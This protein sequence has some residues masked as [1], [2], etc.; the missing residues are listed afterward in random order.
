MQ[1]GKGIGSW[2]WSESFWTPVGYT[3]E[4]LTKEK[5]PGYPDHRDIITY[6]FLFTIIMLILKN[7]IVQPLIVSPL[8]HKLGIPNRKHRKP[9][10]NKLLEGL[11]HQY[12]VTL[13]K[14]VL[15]EVSRSLHWTSRKVER[16][17]RRK[18]AS[19]KQS[20]HEKFVDTAYTWGYKAGILFFGLTVLYDKPYAW[21]VDALWENFP[22]QA[23]DDGIWWLYM[24]GVSFCTAQ[25]VAIFNQPIKRESIIM[26]IH[27]SITVALM[28][29]S[30]VMNCV[31]SG[32]LILILHEV[33]DVILL[34]GKCFRY[35]N[36]ELATDICFTFFVISWM[37]TRLYL[38]PAYILKS[39]F[40]DLPPHMSQVP[41]LY[42]FEILLSCIFL[43]N[44][45]WAV[46]IA[47]MV[48]RKFVE[49]AVK[50]LRSSDEYD[51][52]E[53]TE[54]FSDCKLSSG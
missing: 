41:A 47:A 2:F 7:A 43:L 15:L 54:D 18:Q 31:R 6:P 51:T 10:K 3:W 49:G 1:W 25:T 40:Y 33:N 32:A 53:D 17:L 37:V 9:L 27:H 34:L 39:I 16:W 4:D 21:N 20:E 36:N 19:L 45:Y 29:F 35:L 26:I 13:P 5:I 12:G 52:N 28:G 30:W 46:M 8:T 50:D 11:Y 23:V 48:Y 42:A 38:F 24:I 22:E 14:D 44:V